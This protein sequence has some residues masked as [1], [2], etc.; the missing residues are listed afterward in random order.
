MNQQVEA[1]FEKLH[2]FANTDAQYDQVLH[3]LSQLPAAQ[4]NTISSPIATLLIQ[5]RIDFVTIRNKLKQMGKEA[6]LQICNN[7]ADGVPIEPES[8]SNLC[9]TTM[10]VPGCLIAGVPG[11]GGF[12]AI[13]SI[14]FGGAQDAESVRLRVQDMWTSYGDAI[15]PLLLTESTAKGVVIEK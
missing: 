8:Q 10:Q 13:F 4:W 7:E 1:A 3:D 2:S 12:D 15:C 11:A 6:G 5:L 9:N 14:L